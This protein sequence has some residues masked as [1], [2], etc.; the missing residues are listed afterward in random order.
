MNRCIPNQQSFGLLCTTAFLTM[1]LIT[2][3][4][5][6]QKQETFDKICLPQT[7]KSKAMLSAEDI[8]AKMNF[9]IDKADPEIG[10]ITTR[11]LSSA[12]FFEFWRSDVVGI[13]QALEAN[14]HTTRR[15]IKLNL[16]QNEQDICIDC[17]VSVYRLSLPEHSIS[18]SAK[19]YALFSESTQQTQTLEPHQKQK[20]AMVWIHIGN[21]PDLE[22][23]IL[24]KIKQQL[25]L[26]RKDS[27]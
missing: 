18:S 20:K 17:T 11:P 26:N 13:K 22:M 24:N 15:S 1:T 7:D 2:G 6:K 5:S 3:C 23:T 9:T 10:I 12:Q 4:T 16:V 25:S 8:L 21:D 19:A 27:I 14:I